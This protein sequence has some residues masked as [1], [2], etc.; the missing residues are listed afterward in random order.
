MVYITND[1]PQ[2][3]YCLLKLTFAVDSF[4]AINVNV[5]YLPLY[6]AELL[7]CPKIP[8]LHL[9]TPHS[10]ALG[11]SLLCSLPVLDGC[12][13]EP[14]QAGLFHQCVPLQFRLCSLKDKHLILPHKCHIL[15]INWNFLAVLFC[16]KVRSCCVDSGKFK[17]LILLFQPP[18]CWNHR[19]V[20]WEV[21]DREKMEPNQA[22]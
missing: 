21:V 18:K 6:H 16:L 17:L 14:F 11:T 3:I 4:C 12:R 9:V 15:T 22:K 8:V 2:L 20:I 5:T 7:Q 19:D 1:E 10:Q 13:K